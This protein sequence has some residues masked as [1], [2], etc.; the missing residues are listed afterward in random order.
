ME[1]RCCCWVACRSSG[2]DADKLATRSLSTVLPA[3]ERILRR[4]L[5]YPLEVQVGDSY[6]RP[7]ATGHAPGSVDTGMTPSDSR[8]GRSPTG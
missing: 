5:F 2:I 6:T 8:V 4:F 1:R 7:H 3:K